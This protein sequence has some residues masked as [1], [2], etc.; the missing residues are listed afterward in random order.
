MLG[1][2]YD[3]RIQIDSEWV[4]HLLQFAEFPICDHGYHHFRQ[5]ENLH[6]CLL[7]DLVLDKSLHLV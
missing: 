5:C 6:Q 2:L 7:F 4:R 3:K 1:N